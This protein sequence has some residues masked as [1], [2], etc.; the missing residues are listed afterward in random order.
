M[1]ASASARSR[2]SLHEPIAECAQVSST[3]LKFNHPRGGH[4]ARPDGEIRARLQ[5]LERVGLGYLRS[6]APRR[7]SPAAKRSA[8][9]SPHSSGS[10][11]QGRLLRAR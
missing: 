5:F 6:I 3:N 11:L 8:S 4:R 7:R 10:N 2:R 9:V 1:S